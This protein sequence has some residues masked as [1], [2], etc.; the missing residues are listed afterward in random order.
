MIKTSEMNKIKLQKIYED[1]L[2]KEYSPTTDEDLLKAVDT[3]IVQHKNI[4]KYNDID[5]IIKN[6]ACII[7]YDHTAGNVGHWCCLT[8]R[9]NIIE[10]F[11]S[12]GRN[13]DDK[14]YIG[15]RI[16]Y[17]KNLLRKSN[18]IVT[19][20]PFDFQKKRVAT[21]GRHVVTR[22]LFKNYPLEHYKNF[23]DNIDS[24]D[25]VSFLTLPI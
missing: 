13:I 22:I 14:R 12:Y 17:L 3:N 16:P 23:M 11:D 5:Q 6:N 4:S 15:N 19:Y 10:F 1:M 20:N 24:D 18:Y 2:R 25:L 9:G 21:C 7:F 8:K